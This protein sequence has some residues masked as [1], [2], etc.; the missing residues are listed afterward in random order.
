MRIMVCFFNFIEL[1]VTWLD[2]IAEGLKNVI[3]SSNDFR[4]FVD[5]LRVELRWK[6]QTEPGWLAIVEPMRQCIYTLGV[7][8]H[9]L[10]SPNEDEPTK[11]ESK[12]KKDEKVDLSKLVLLQGGLEDRFIPELSDKT[13]E[14]IEG[15]FKIT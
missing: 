3:A 15:F 1:E 9:K 8:S 12:E 10:I 5:G 6:V 11:D 14:H 2:E 13:K 4:N 7:V